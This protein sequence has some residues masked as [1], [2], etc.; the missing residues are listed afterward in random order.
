MS[1]GFTIAPLQRHL[2][3]PSR[4]KLLNGVRLRN[5]VLQ[6]VIELMSLSRKGGKRSGR[7]RISYSTLGINQ[8]GAVY[9]SYYR[10]YGRRFV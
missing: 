4:T 8:L 1:N 5:S 2:F 9:E 3:D 7:G 6:R 10:V